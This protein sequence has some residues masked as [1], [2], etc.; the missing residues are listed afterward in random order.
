MKTI[1]DYFRAGHGEWKMGALLL[2]H[3][4]TRLFFMV[5]ERAT[6][7]DVSSL[8]LMLYSHAL[9]V[10]PQLLLGLCWQVHPDILGS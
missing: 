6:S 1:P 2:G 5:A 7:L 9:P 3:K 8:G 10:T 4:N